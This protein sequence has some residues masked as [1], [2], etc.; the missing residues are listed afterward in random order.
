MS[1]ATAAVDPATGFS[2]DELKVFIRNHFEDFVNRQDLDAADRNFAPSFVDHGDD[3][4]PNLPRG[5][6][7]AKQYLAAA[8]KR[9]TDIQVTIEDMVAEGDKVVVRNWWT[10]TDSQSNQKIEF[11]GI[12]IWRI[13]NRKIVER[14]AYLQKPHPAA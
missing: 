13:E 14:W 1:T 7:G 3:V 9:F 8:F 2:H 5:I 10:A 6:E 4:P 11:R 12:V